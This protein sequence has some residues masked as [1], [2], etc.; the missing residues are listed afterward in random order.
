MKKYILQIFLCL[1]SFSCFAKYVVTGD[2]VLTKNDNFTKV[3]LL[4]GLNGAEISYTSPNAIKHQW[5][6]YRENTGN[7]IPVSCIQTGNTSVIKDLEDGWG[8][9]VENSA[10]I[11]NYYLWITDYSKHKS[12]FKSIA[13][14]NAEDDECY[15]EIIAT[16]NDTLV[17]DN[18]LNGSGSNISAPATFTF[19]ANTSSDITSYRWNIYNLNQTATNLVPFLNRGDTVLIFTFKQAGQYGVDLEVSNNDGSCTY[20]TTYADN[21][22]I[23]DFMLWAPN[24]FSPTSSPGVN[25]IFKVAYKSADL[26]NFKGWI[27]NS[28]GNELFYWTDPTQGWDGKYR[29]KFVPPGTYFYVIEAT[30]FNGKKHVKKGDV[31]IIGGR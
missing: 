8:Y 3:Y 21:I 13:H 31:S 10:D 15:A 11:S 6:K 17:P 26:A 16:P 4:N 12:D 29:G 18:Q 27:Y 28:W 2:I 9:Y 5:Y 1:L 30:D 23:S 22:I 14:K 25:D 19:K 20:P 7:R 24:A